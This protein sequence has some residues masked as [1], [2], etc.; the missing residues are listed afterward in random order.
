MKEIRLG[1]MMTIGAM[2]AAP[3]VQAQEV[4]AALTEEPTA[5]AQPDVKQL[6]EPTSIVIVQPTVEILAS[7]PQTHVPP[8]Q[9]IAPPMTATVTPRS[10]TPQFSVKDFGT[11]SITQ[12]SAAVKPL[13]IAI[14]P[15][16]TDVQ[17][18]NAQPQNAQPQPIQQSTIPQ[19]PSL[20]T[21]TSLDT[22]ISKV[23]VF[24]DSL[25]DSGTRSDPKNQTSLTSGYYLDGRTS[26]GPLW[27]EQLAIALN[28]PTGLDKFAVGG[29]QST[30]SQRQINMYMRE[31]P[32]I[33]SSDLHAI[34]TGTNDYRLGGT[35]PDLTV[36]N[37]RASVD[38]LIAAGAK[39][40]LVANVMGLGNIPD[41]IANTSASGLAP[42]SQDHNKRLHEELKDI[43]VSRNDL[44]LVPLDFNALFTEMLADPN[45]F[46]F[47][48]DSSSCL[49]Q[50]TN[51][52]DF[53]FLDII[54]P[55]EAA[56]R[57]LSDYTLSILNAPQTIAPQSALAMEI[58]KQT[59]QRIDTQLDLKQQ[60]HNFE[61]NDQLTVFTS[62]EFSFGD[63]SAINDRS[64]KSEF[65]T[66]AM[67]IGIM[68]NLSSDFKFGLALNHAKSSSSLAG[69]SGK[70]SIE[71]NSL[72]LYGQKH[73]DRFFLNG[74][75][76]YGWN[77]FD[78]S[79]ALKVTGFDSATA[80]PT[81]NQFS[82]QV[83]AGYNIGDLESSGFQ[84]TPTVG[85]GYQA[86]NIQEYNE[87]NGSIL[88]LNVKEQNSSSAVVSVGSKLSYR[89]RVNKATITP[90][91]NIN[92]EHAL[93]DG[94][95]E[96][97]TE[98]LTQKDI[99]IRSNTGKVDPDLIRLG[100]GVRSQMEGGV[101]LALGY[102]TIL[103][104]TVLNSHALHGQLQYAF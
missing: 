20:N 100:L 41:Y 51:P 69:N 8:T 96:I 64:G 16:T 103:S 92:Y 99:P 59:I 23:V 61:K 32:E 70:M 60:G 104:R 98:I 94:N 37:I 9:V 10:I 13:V 95:R 39:K 1:L 35:R 3:T 79:R 91:L 56:N 88:N 83:K 42:L 82:V 34:W 29:T 44:Y 46:K 19:I 33:K 58:M 89:I 87:S 2:A 28:N 26:N 4:P 62:G 86:N 74:I 24:G 25:S 52:N 67:T 27:T 80:S 76:D 54:H 101:S 68:K 78:I 43:A 63:Q 72:S 57:I 77:K 6:V 48:K 45:R 97:I 22:T 12:Q 102:E 15:P 73:F 40:I 84:I 71:N 75:V 18:Q 81:G 11:D 47:R 30:D 93:T 21:N 7:E 14:A 38:T 66:T 85:I 31:T 55:T 17:P 5:L 53:I 50:C 49:L 65:A 36:N 90:Y